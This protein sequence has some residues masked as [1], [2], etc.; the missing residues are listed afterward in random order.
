M[1]EGGAAMV[2]VEGADYVLD[3]I[4]SLARHS[5]PVCAHL[6]LTPQSVHKLGGYR[7][8]GKTKI[9]ASVCSPTHKP[10]KRRAPICWCWNVCRPLWPNASANN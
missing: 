7:V 6:G 2:K 10:S 8:Q 4:G 3:V 5:I 9:G 1:A